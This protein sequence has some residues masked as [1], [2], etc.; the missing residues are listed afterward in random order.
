MGQGIF[1]R[2]KVKKYQLYQHISS[3]HVNLQY[4]SHE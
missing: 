4:Y 1:A 2:M 3:F